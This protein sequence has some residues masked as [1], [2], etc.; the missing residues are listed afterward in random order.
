MNA[1]RAP[2]AAIRADYFFMAANDLGIVVFNAHY[3]DIYR[4]LRDTEI[5][6]EGGRAHYGD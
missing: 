5:G 6:S 2:T 3:V 1:V 4:L